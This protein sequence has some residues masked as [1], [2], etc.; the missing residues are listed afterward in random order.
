MGAKRIAFDDEARQA[1]RRGVSQ[2]AK[3]VKVT[4]GPRGR[5]VMIER[6]IMSPLVTKDGVTVAKELEFKDSW[7]NMGA[8]MVK[9]VASKTSD[10]AGDG[11]TTATV[12]AEAIFERGLVA[13]QSGVQPV[14]FKRGIEQ[15]TKAVVEELRGMSVDVEGRDHIA[16]VGTIAANNDPTIGEVLAQ[17][18]EKVGKDGVITVDEGNSLKTEVEFVDG[19]SF[20]RGYLS[21]YFATDTTTLACELEDARVLVTSEKISSINDLVGVL[22][23]VIQVDKPLMIIAEDV[24]GEA[25]ALLVVNKMRGSLKV[26]AIKAP[27]FGDDRKARLEDIAT[28]CGAKLVSKETGVNLETLTIDELGSAS[29]VVVRKDETEIV[30]GGGDAE[31]VKARLGQ[32]RAQLEKT[33]NTYDAEKLEERI[34]KIAGGVARILIGAATETEMKERKALIEDAIHATRAATEEGIVPGGGVALLRASQAIDSLDLSGDQAL[35]ARVVKDALSE[36]IRQIARNAGYPP[37]VV[38]ERILAGSEPAFG[39]NALTGEYGDLKAAGVIDPTK[40]SRTAFENAVSVATMLLT[41][42]CLVGEPV[43]DEED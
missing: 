19:M 40:V 39:L 14:L 18:M 32:I 21:P 30:G 33:S 12:L 13:L 11:T 29:K 34:A 8:Q 2:L 20:Q 26:C 16:Q 10:G 24:E 17:A 4:L 15:A 43:E 38:V 22:E 27:G 31:L 25:L 3:T 28:M 7:E 23:A 9:E 5:N 35:G 37:A 42:D 36:P 41:T 1:I 6:G